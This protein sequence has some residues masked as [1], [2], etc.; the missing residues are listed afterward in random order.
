MLGLEQPPRRMESYDISNQGAS[1][2]VASMVVYADGR[3]LK[4]DYRR[5]KL[6]DM[7][8]PDDYASMEQVLTRRFRRYLEGDEKFADRPDLLLIDGRHAVL[9]HHADDVGVLQLTNLLFQLAV[10]ALQIRDFAFVLLQLSTELHN[11]R[12]HIVHSPLRQAPITV[13]MG[14]PIA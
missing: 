1:D 9:T 6:K 10:A 4:R 13:E 3:P 2:I 7:T 5:F 14:L 11:F 12:V 8:G